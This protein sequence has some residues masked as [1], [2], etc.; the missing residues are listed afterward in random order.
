[1]S[2]KFVRASKY[3]HVFG[4][5]FKIDQQYSGTKMT[6]SAWDSNMIACGCK[7]FSMIW[8]VAGGGAFAVIP[9]TKVGK[10]VDVCLVSGHK[11]T[12]LDI[13]Y[14]PFNDNLIASVSEDC[15]ICIW[16]IPEECPAGNIHEA[17]QTL[18]GHKR[19]V[20]TCN[21][22]PCA[23]NV[24]ATSSAD[25]TIKIWDIEQ[26]EEMFSIGGFTDII[27]S[28][29]WNRIGSELVS[30]CKDKKIRIIDPRQQT[31]AS[32]V[33]AHQGSKG[34]RCLWMQN[35][36][37]IFTT[38]FSRNAEREMAFWDPRNLAT[39]LCR[40]TVDNQSGVLMPFYDADSSIL[41]LGGKGD[42][43]ISYFEI[44]HEK[45]YFYSLNTFRGEKP[46]SGLGV[47]PKRVCNTTTCEITR[48]MKV[49]R[50]GVVP[51]SFCVP[52]KSEIFQDDIFPN[53]YA[54][55]PVETA[56]EWKEG[57][58]N[59]PDMSFN[60]APGF[61]PPEKPA[62]SF[63]PVVK[64]VEAPKSDK[65]IREE[66][67]QLKNRVNYLETELAKKDAQIAELQSKLAAG[68]Q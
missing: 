67:E 18:Q 41:Y 14:N 64:K 1:M 62:A 27:N 43:G 44:V 46:Q 61:V 17:A 36:E 23:S 15:N 58:S 45:P 55:I 39:P 11:G 8:D 30:T 21:F 4:T 48:F 19:K 65:E 10:Q 22:N 34:M 29:A 40:H 42:S 57:T 47:I 28:V 51:I 31:V 2:G 16:N 54:G 35:N 6:K 12:V 59:E 37:M 9:Y 68:S 52:R 53:T 3:R 5:E 33:L 66:W 20:G 32:D 63:N 24:L 13:D 7:H 49:T 60:F 26:G 38:G 56:N 25:T 50:D